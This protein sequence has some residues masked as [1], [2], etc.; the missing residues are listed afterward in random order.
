MLQRI[1][2][3]IDFEALRSTLVTERET[4]LKTNAFSDER[5]LRETEDAE[6]VLDHLSEIQT[7]LFKFFKEFPSLIRNFQET[8]ISLPEFFSREY[9]LDICFIDDCLFPEKDLFYLG[10]DGSLDPLVFKIQQKEFTDWIDVTKTVHLDTQKF[11]KTEFDPRVRFADLGCRCQQCQ[12]DYRSQL[13]ES[14]FNRGSEILESAQKMIKD[15]GDKEIQ[16]YFQTFKKM[17]TEVDQLLI[18]SRHQLKR[19]TINRLE[20]QFKSHIRRNFAY[21][22]ELSQKVVTKLKPVLKHS[23]YDQGYSDDIISEEEFVKFFTQIQT[24]LWRGEKYLIKEFK[25]FFRSLLLLKRKDVSSKIL[26]TYLGE[27]WTH[28]QA[29]TLKRKI[30]YHMGPTNSGKTYHAIQALKAAEKGC[31]L[32]PLRLLAAE[33]YDTL[34]HAG[35]KTTLLT[36][37]EVIEESEATHVSSTIEMA[38]FQQ[39]F[40]CAVIDEIQMIKDPQRGWAWTRALVNIF[41]PVIHVCGDHSAYDLVKNIADLC[42]DEIEV[43]NYERMTEL[44]V[45]EKSIYLDQL[46]KGDALI[47]FSR[48]N[49]LRYKNE[50]EKLD[51]KVS[52]VYGRLSP[53]VRREQARKFD[54][55][56]TDIIVSTDAISM[57]MNLPIR[58][59]VFSTLSKYINNKEYRISASEI[60]QIAGR[61]GRYKRFPTGYVTTL[62]KVD[63][64]LDIIEDAL[65]TNLAQSEKC[66][67]GPDLDIF[68]QVNGELKKHELPHL[69]FSEFLRLFYTMKFKRPF[70]CVELA[71]MIELS[72]MV[73]DSDKTKILTDAEVFGFACAPVNMGLIDHVQFYMSIVNNYTAQKP[74]LYRPIEHDSYDID[75]LETS[76][77]C[78]ELYQWLARH[79]NNKNF[80]FDATEI[81]VNKSSAIDKLNDLL[82]DKWSSS[83]IVKQFSPY[84]SRRKGSGKGKGHYKKGKSSK[85]S[86]GFRKKKTKFKR[87]SSSKFNKFKRK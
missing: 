83:N 77:K 45:E 2:Q 43:K 71:E 40:D 31:Y 70:F 63:R 79:F 1:P 66:M 37:E 49:A 6:L 29:R 5:L 15:S 32:A 50:L 19:S 55:G 35:V 11:L 72:E 18:K 65:Q 34:N 46:Q 75:Y 47:V 10:P 23:L 30:V 14:L 25:K 39:V 61:A 69:K 86:G 59:I 3:L 33:L 36:G 42:G 60:K 58:R 41:S 80:D 78:V 85:D 53:E 84:H 67:V 17:K 4:L 27:F 12:S 81:A 24:N 74:I 52:I 56:E 8:Y 38:R 57:G 48:R 68:S 16:F 13:R 82:S 28:S 54:E 9:I 44:K 20:D 51:F 62:K 21:P 87:K 73:E 76:I 7:K 26:N 22:S 64:G